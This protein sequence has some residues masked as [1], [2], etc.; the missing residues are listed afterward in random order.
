VTVPVRWLSLHLDDDEPKIA[1]GY[2][3]Q[4][5]LEVLTAH[6]LWAPP[7]F[8]VFDHAEGDPSC[9]PSSGGAVVA[10]GARWH[11]EDVGRLNEA[12][13]RLSWLILVLTGDEEGAFPVHLV[14][15]PNMKVWLQ[16]PHPHNRDFA[17]RVIGDWWPPKCRTWSREWQDSFYPSLDGWHRDSWFFA[18]NINN[19]RRAECLDVLRA[20]QNA[21][22]DGTLKATRV[23]GAGFD[24]GEYMRLTLQAKVI[25]CPS[26]CFSSD[27]FRVYEAMEA[28]SVP[29]VDRSAP[30]TPDETDYWETLFHVPPPFPILDHWS[31]FDAVCD[32]ILADWPAWSNRCGAW[33]EA[34]KRAH[35][36]D[37]IDDLRAVGAI[38]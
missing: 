7:G 11:V 28:G 10:L 13:G 12:L 16:T 37:L 35:A 15:H 4:G 8:P 18:G 33:W 24:Y 19:E 21:R 20:R 5:W 23:F 6:E 3:D 14:S 38:E 31:Q 30:K 32:E 29:V 25:P 17:D 2:W 1:R 34:E 36:W 9:L 22:G 26:G 27:T